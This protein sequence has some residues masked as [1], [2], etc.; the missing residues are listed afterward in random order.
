MNVFFSAKGETQVKPSN[1]RSCSAGHT[2]INAKVKSVQAVDG[3][4]LTP[5]A[6]LDGVFGDS[7]ASVAVRDGGFARLAA[8]LEGGVT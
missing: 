1:V 3:A 5:F 8:D 7:I 2:K 6:L 4:A